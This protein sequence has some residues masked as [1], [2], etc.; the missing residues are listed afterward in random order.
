[1]LDMSRN[2]SPFFEGSIGE[3]IIV[4]LASPPLAVICAEI[5]LAL[6]DCFTGRL[7]RDWRDQ[8]MDFA[9]LAI[10]SELIGWFFMLLVLAFFWALFRPIWIERLLFYV[11]HHVFLGM[12]FFLIGFFVSLAICIAVP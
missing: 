7:G 5:L 9:F 8:F 3:R 12:W 1:M 4:A 10:F 6:H 2:E 11:R